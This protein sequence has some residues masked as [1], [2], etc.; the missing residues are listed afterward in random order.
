MNEWMNEWMKISSRAWQEGCHLL[1]SFFYFTDKD[2]DK[3]SSLGD[4]LLILKISNLKI[5][6]S[7]QAEKFEVAISTRPLNIA[8]FPF[9]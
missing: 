3:L 4:S 2:I 9:N 8:N 1:L 6:E 7:W 5:S